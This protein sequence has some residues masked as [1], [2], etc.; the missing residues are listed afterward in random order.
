MKYVGLSSAG[1]LFLTAL[2]ITCSAHATSPQEACES[3]TEENFTQYFYEDS[4]ARVLLDQ[5]CETPTAEQLSDKAAG[6]GDCLC[7][8]KNVTEILQQL[9]TGRG[10]VAVFTHRLMNVARGKNCRDALHTCE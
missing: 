8:D 3:G 4:D 2:T 1:W 10:P 9:M 7:Y 5:R 6:E